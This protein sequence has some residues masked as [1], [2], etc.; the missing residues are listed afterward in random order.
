MNSLPDHVQQY[1]TSPVFTEETVPKGLLKNH[2][3]KS[4]VWGLICVSEGELEYTI[5][6]KEVH[7]LNPNKKGVVEPEIKHHI[8]PLGSVSFYIKFFK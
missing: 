4:G 6:D 3:T 8:K 1:S 5:E 2:N 7:I